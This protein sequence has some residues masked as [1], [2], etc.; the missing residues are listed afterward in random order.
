[1]KLVIDYHYHI[2]F[3]PFRCRNGRSEPAEASRTVE[4]RELEDAAAPV[5]M[6]VGNPKN[7]HQ[8]RHEARYAV[9]PDGSP[10]K[11]RYFEGRH[12]VEA[13]SAE[14]LAADVASNVN[15]TFFGRAKPRDGAVDGQQTRR[16]VMTADQVV[17]KHSK[18]AEPFVSFS[19]DKGKTVGDKLE[20]LAAL[21]IAVNG[22]VYEY[23]PEPILKVDTRHEKKA[24]IQPR[25]GGRWNLDGFDFHAYE[26]LEPTR[27]SLK[28]G[29]RIL[30]LAP[31]RAI[32]VFEVIDPRTSTFD[33]VTFD[34][35]ERV[36][37]L[38]SHLD[39]NVV[40][41]PR[42]A[43]EA[44]YDLR[45]AR[46]DA[47]DRATPRLVAAV[48]AVSRLQDHSGSRAAAAVDK[49]KAEMAGSPSHTKSIVMQR[50]E[51]AESGSLKTARELAKFALQRWECRPAEAHWENGVAPLSSRSAGGWRTVEV[52]SEG[53]AAEKAKTAGISRETV[54]QAASDGFRIIVCEPIHRLP[55]ENHHIAIAAASPDGSVT[56]LGSRGNVPEPDR[57]FREHL[58]MAE[59]S[60]SD[61]YEADIMP[62]LDGGF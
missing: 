22:T 49:R 56:V 33:G 46:T 21:M 51:F 54:L 27:S 5:V 8:D 37:K 55:G 45:D 36:E 62:A 38:F 35:A 23:T 15:K 59:A 31:K 40:G 57:M 47:A 42:E 16:P 24:S 60:R 19:D 28:H 44:F 52:L 9:K 25:P 17:M 58:E 18:R 14:Q 53:R 10:R 13:G 6:L 1:M 20:R 26:F 7:Q 4:V 48:E 30:H 12:F 29:H 50:A 61:H 34:F 11:V 3:V 43:L 32:P 39:S 2:N 41:L